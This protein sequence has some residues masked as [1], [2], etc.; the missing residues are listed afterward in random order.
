ML[1]IP[2]LFRF[3]FALGV[4][5]GFGST[6]ISSVS[7]QYRGAE[8]P[9]E[10]VQIGFESITEAVSE[11]WL[12]ILVGKGFDGRGT[13]Q[14]GY[15]RAAH[16]VA[17]K[18]AEFGFQP[19]GDEGTYFQN[20]PFRQIAADAAASSVKI[21]EVVFQGAEQIGFTRASDSQRVSGPVVL[22]K[23][24]GEGVMFDKPET[25]AGHVVI[26]I[27]GEMPNQVSRQLEFQI[28]AAEPA[29]IVRLSAK[30]AVSVP[31]LLRPGQG[32]LGPQRITAELSASCREDLAKA[33]GVESS[34]LEPSTEVGL[35]T[36]VLSGVEGTV[37]LKS[38]ET[39]ATVP[40]VVGWYPGSD[41]KLAHEY[42]VIGAHLDHL[43]YQ[44]EELF[45]GADD[46]GSGSTAILQIA[47]ALHLNPI[48]PKRSVLYIAFAAEEMGL[49]GS[50]HFVENPIRP[51][52]DCVC[53]LNID[54]IGRNEETEQ[55]K[56][57]E[58]EDSIHLVGTTQLSKSLHQDVLEAN[59]HVG[60]RFEYD[61]ERVYRR[62][63][64]YSFA[65]KEVPSSF[66]FGG[67]NPYYHQTTDTLDGINYSKIANC[68]RLYYLMT[69][70]AGENGR[71]PLD[72]EEVTGE[73]K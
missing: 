43:G 29:A 25:V 62:S 41:P 61:E 40:N 58:N 50:N 22:V 49:I 20:L 17:G 2:R 9:P 44:G 13:G 47:Q 26:L 3:S 52:K 6:G 14:E 67:F 33:L 30:Q 18:L 73:G 55:E 71:Y 63:D 48:K 11:E 34:V 12:K 10:A 38:V 56:A 5:F 68:A 39:R 36:Q 59:R 7:A 69:F 45:P 15:V 66:L 60:F 1:G 24:T 19:I 37:D 28:L 57:T 32:A 21:G 46:N 54:M 8:P 70:R 4:C 35:S 42:V 31:T 64:H 72:A 23:A 53:M 65:R 27:C 51:L 16:F